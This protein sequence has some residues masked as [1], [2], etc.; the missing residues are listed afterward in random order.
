[1]LELLMVL[2]NGRPDRA[3][4]EGI[5]VIPPLLISVGLHLGECEASKHN[6]EV[7]E[8]REVY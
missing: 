4:E 2:A 3:L 1:V 7:R 5:G 8:W 6:Q